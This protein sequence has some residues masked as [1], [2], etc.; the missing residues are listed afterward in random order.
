MNTNIKKL[1]FPLNNSCRPFLLAVNQSCIVLQPRFVITVPYASEKTF[2][3]T[4]P[5]TVD[6]NKTGKPLRTHV[7]R[8]SNTYLRALSGR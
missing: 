8:P 5:V 6:Q 3:Y 1:L 2:S 7:G 4:R